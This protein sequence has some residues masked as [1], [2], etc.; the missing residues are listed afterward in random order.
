MGGQT[1]LA[2]AMN[3]LPMSKLGLKILTGKGKVRGLRKYLIL[4]KMLILLSE[5]D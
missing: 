2:L 4:K 1:Y 3:R 5:S